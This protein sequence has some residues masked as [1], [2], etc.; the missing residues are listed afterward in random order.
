[1]TNVLSLII[2]DMLVSPKYLVDKPQVLEVVLR[3]LQESPILQEWENSD[4][5]QLQT[6]LSNCMRQI[7]FYLLDKISRIYWEVYQKNPLLFFF[8]LFWCKENVKFA[9]PKT[10]DWQWLWRNFKTKFR[11]KHISQ[12]FS[13]CELT[14]SPRN[15]T[16]VALFIRKCLRNM[17]LWLYVG[18]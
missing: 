8:P 10:G 16:K 12:S 6:K 2:F 5:L 7:L 1:M 14:N 17:W 13:Y 3:E 4:G 15:G 11:W 9:R 18:S